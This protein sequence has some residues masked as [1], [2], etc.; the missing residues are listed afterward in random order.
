[1]RHGYQLFRQHALAEGMAQSGHYDL[2]VSAVA[3]DERNDALDAA[4]GR[5]GIPE[6][7][8]WGEVF[9]GRARFA[10]FTHQ[11]WIAWVQQHDTRG[12]WSDWLSY[13][14]SRYGL[15]E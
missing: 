10:A 15:G 4:L 11:E 7:K 6:L 5:S 3:V 14:R 1:M 9:R 13:V 12:I 2:I 8:R